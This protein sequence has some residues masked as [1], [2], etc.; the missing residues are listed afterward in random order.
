MWKKGPLPPGTYNWGG[1]VLVGDSPDG[2]Y[3]ADFCGDHAIVLKGKIGDTNSVDTRVE[4]DQ[5]AMYNNSLELPPSHVMG[6]KRK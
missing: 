1:V 3:F 2:F 4:A 6:S 5:I